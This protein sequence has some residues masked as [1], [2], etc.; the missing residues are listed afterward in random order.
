MPMAAWTRASIPAPERS[1]TA[2]NPS[3]IQQDSRVAPDSRVFV[4]ETG[5]Q[6]RS[7][8]C[9]RRRLIR[10][11][12]VTRPCTAEDVVALSAP[13]KSSMPA[14]G[15][16][17][18][19]R[20]VGDVRVHLHASG[21][22]FRYG[23]IDLCTSRCPAARRERQRAYKPLAATATSAAI[24]LPD[25]TF[26]AGQQHDE[27]QGEGRCATACWPKRGRSRQR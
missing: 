27:T 7:T 17:C 5:E 11:Y 26:P 8:T 21:R 14:T 2:C 3:P 16:S 22:R 10:L 15:T 18:S 6:E 24:V 12:G 4:G 23:A 1:R 25:A 20:R 13:P 19:T 9:S